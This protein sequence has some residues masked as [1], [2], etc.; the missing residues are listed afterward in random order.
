VWKNNSARIV[1]IAV[2]NY[3]INGVPIEK[4]ITE[5]T[6]IFDYCILGKANRGW[7]IYQ[8]DNKLPNVN[9]YYVSSTQNLGTLIKVNDLD[10]RIISLE[11]HPNS[12]KGEYYN[13]QVIND[14]NKWHGNLD[15]NYEYYINS[16]NKLVDAIYN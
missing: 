1:P 9:R 5:H 6:D 3:L 10:G 2:S 15:I 8:G 16:A 14:I 12:K 13:L 11:A 4:T 7:S